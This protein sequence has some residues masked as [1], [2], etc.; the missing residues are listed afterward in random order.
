MVK[1]YVQDCPQ[2]YVHHKEKQMV[3]PRFHIQR[4]DR[5]LSTTS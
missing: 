2:F 1:L 4:L 3:V 5:S